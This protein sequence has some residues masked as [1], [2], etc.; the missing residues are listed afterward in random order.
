M[1]V[2]RRGREKGRRKNEGEEGGARTRRGG[3]EWGEGAGGRGKG[4]NRGGGRE[5]A[6]LKQNERGGQGRR[7]REWRAGCDRDL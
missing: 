4:E 3:G 5:N 2:E 7:W 1:T 6:S